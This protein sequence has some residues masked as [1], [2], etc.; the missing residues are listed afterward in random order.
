MGKRCWQWALLLLLCCAP[1]SSIQRQVGASQ[2]PTDRDGGLGDGGSV[3]PSSVDFIDLDGDVV[4]APFRWQVLNVDDAIKKSTSASSNTL[5]VLIFINDELAFDFLLDG[6][7][8]LSVGFSGA[9]NLAPGEY[10]VTIKL[11]DAA[12]GGW[13]GEQY[14]LFSAL[15]E[16]PAC[17]AGHGA[18]AQ[19][20]LTLL[21]AFET[22]QLSHLE[23]LTRSWPGPISAAIF[24]L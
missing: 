23:A 8:K 5:V 14:Y 24:V 7:K 20:S 18:C 19:H 22:D 11:A 6:G 15:R 16:H 13:V 4:V 9:E 17:L 10:D 1:P 2:V 21:G 12:S 3:A